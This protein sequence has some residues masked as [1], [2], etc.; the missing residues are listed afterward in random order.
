MN[1][2]LNDT[3]AVHPHLLRVRFESGAH[4]LFWKAGTAQHGTGTGTAQKRPKYRKDN[5]TEKMMDEEGG[6]TRH[7][8]SE[9]LGGGGGKR[10]GGGGGEKGAKGVGDNRHI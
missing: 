8:Q 4:G 1:E 6:A 3:N 2:D 9:E 7:F 5:K 10:Y